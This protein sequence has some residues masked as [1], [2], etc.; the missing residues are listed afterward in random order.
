MTRVGCRFLI[1]DA[2]K[3]AIPFYEKQEMQLLETDVN[4][5]KENPIMFIDLCDEVC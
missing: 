3:K 5:A 2:K 4:R 1:T